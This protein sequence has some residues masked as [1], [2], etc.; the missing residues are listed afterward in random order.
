M[1]VLRGTLTFVLGLI[2]GILLFVIAIGG[3]VLGLGLSVSVGKLQDT[4]IGEEVF[5]PDSEIYDKNVWHAAKDIILSD[6][7]NFDSLSLKTLYE[8]YGIDFFK[9][10]SGLD[11]TTKDFYDKPITSLVK[12]PSKLINSF[13]L[14]DVS[15][16]TQIDF[17]SYGL[18]IL[19]DNMN[20]GLNVAMDNILN[21]LNGS[22]S[23][24]RIK[25]TLG[26]DLGV[27]DNKLLSD[28]QD[29]GLDEF[30]SVI[31]VLMLDTILNVDTDTF[32]PCGE[33]TKYVY[34]DKYEEVSATE[35]ADKSYIPKTGAERYFP[36]G[37]D[38]DGDGVADAMNILEMRYKKTADGKYVIDN[39][40]Y[41][42]DFDASENTQKYYRRLEYV[43]VTT[44]STPPANETNVFVQGYANKI[45][46]VSATGYT[47][48]FKELV[49]VSLI[50]DEAI[51]DGGK[52]IITDE[53]IDNDSAL[54]EVDEAQ[55]YYIR[56]HK[57]TATALLQSLNY[58]TVR[59][60]Q[61]ADEIVSN[62]TIGDIVDAETASSKIIKAL[63]DSTLKTIGDD[64]NDLALSD[65]I[66]IVSDEYV[67]D[68]AHGK[69]VYSEEDGCYALYNPAVH[70]DPNVQR[71]G[72]RKVDGA[73]SSVLQRFAGASLG[74]FSTAFDSLS[75][76]D[77]MDIDADVYAV[78]S[79]QYI[80]EN[81]DERYY[82]YDAATSVYRIADEGFRS[83][84]S[85]A[86]KVYFRIAS[87]GT[88]SNILKKLAYVKVDNMAD[89]MEAV[90]D[91]MMLSEL[92]DIYSENAVELSAP[93]FGE[94]SEYFIEYD[95]ENKLCADDG[96]NK[97]VYVLDSGG[98][99][100]FSDFRYVT[101]TSSQLALEPS[102][103]TANNIYY[104][105]KPITGLS[106]LEITA[107][108]ALG[109]LYY[110]D[111]GVY[112]HDPTFC[113]YVISLGA[114]D[115][116]YGNVYY[117]AS[118]S[119][120]DAGAIAATVY[121]GAGSDKVYVRGTISGF[122]EVTSVNLA[123]FADLDYFVKETATSPS[124]IIPL[125]D[126][127]ITE[128]ENA[129]KYSLRRCETIYVKDDMGD[130]VYDGGQYVS[131]DESVHSTL[132][133]FTKKI[134]YIS[135]ANKLYVIQS[136]TGDRTPIYENAMTVSRYVHKK[137][138]PVLLLLAT[139][140]VS[141][142]SDIIENATVSNLIDAEEGSLFDNEM[143]KNSKISEL[144]NA[145]KVLLANMTIGDLIHWSNIEGM[146]GTVKELLKTV[147]AIDFFTS[148][149][150]KGGV[151]Y[152]NMFKLY[153]YESN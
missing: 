37:K 81:P 114:A 80:T 34:C 38:T 71:Y 30:G 89:S 35:L 8:H 116:H 87:S 101:K 54:E 52:W 145:F 142:M 88:S 113:T 48:L 58:M 76:A 144:G 138:A 90:I 146:N 139:G 128:A 133:R 50:T 150:Y 56:I 125:S 23:I 69:Y 59:E 151:M 96:E 147:S 122:T 31:N 67:P 109:N 15:T 66:D 20:V 51:R 33:L 45:D 63:K 108:G 43:P 121:T 134:G 97:F 21:S 149:E 55:S 130:F 22:I 127:S 136:G 53:V 123:A 112:H 44:L 65:V 111:G 32:I 36:N 104:S 117:K 5:S 14:Q 26:I 119:S 99:V 19:D 153:G 140:T 118:A 78:A 148:L 124:F 84:P 28:L 11:F 3:T 75:I 137:S 106:S 49:P 25:D 7:Q 47:L 107:Q 24:R 27:N 72:K 61:D 10:I 64:I 83:D 2:I 68:N 85:N 98:K 152:V 62:L 6:I 70:T 129:L 13:T 1:R 77:V 41:N 74:G 82:Y 79:P 86:D 115:S 132:D 92:I 93:V 29:V 46:T 135:T 103:Y 94:N 120:T 131:Y 95:P 40:C 143:I 60:L 141:N 4:F 12:E 105:Y 9:G 110:L 39:S 42:E 16:L 100:T 57:G 102:K 17:S 126:L 18:P 91:D 73:S